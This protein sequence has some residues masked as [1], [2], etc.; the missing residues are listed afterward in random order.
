[1]GAA[2]SVGGAAGTGIGAAAGGPVGAAIGGAAGSVLGGLLDSEKSPYDIWKEQQARLNAI[3]LPTLQEL[4]RSGQID[5]S[6]LA[7]LQIDPATRAAQMDA[8]N[9]MS[10]EY[11]RGGA[12]VTSRAA[13][14]QLL[15]RAQQQE[16]SDRE[17]IMQEM[18]GRGQLGGGTELAARLT[19]QQG[20]YRGN[21]LSGA[22]IAGDDRLRALQ[23][24]TDAGRTA[25][26]V[27]GQDT[28][29][30]ATRAQAHDAL[31]RWNAQN[32]RSAYGDRLG[33]QFQKATGQAQ[34]AGGMA[35]G[36]Q[37]R[38]QR[39]VDT[40][41][42]IGTAAGGVIDYYRQRQQQPDNGSDQSWD[43]G[44][45]AYGTSSPSEW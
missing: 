21:A 15:D 5:K 34:A 31:D 2:S 23:A 19:G 38:Y 43:G 13:Q 18:A 20:Q 26:T 44:D 17:A 30:A 45:S 41:G 29:L 8:L 37:E 3:D 32:R 35:A 36:A 4:I 10:D 40:G 33:W 11:R 27:R 14:A 9:A 24:M 16:R 25:T 22:Q 28:D 42:A 7:D 39:G 6:A 12:S 1:M